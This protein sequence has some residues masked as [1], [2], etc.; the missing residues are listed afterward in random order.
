[1]RGQWLDLWDLWVFL[2][3][4]LQPD[5]HYRNRLREEVD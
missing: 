1:M 4:S 3:W 2:R 5:L